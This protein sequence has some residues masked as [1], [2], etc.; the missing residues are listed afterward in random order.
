MGNGERGG[1]E[2]QMALEQESAQQERVPPAGGRRNFV[3]A[4]ADRRDGPHFAHGV[5]D[6]SALLDAG[7]SGDYNP[8]GEVLM[9]PASDFLD[10]HP[11]ARLVP[12]QPVHTG[13]FDL[14]DVVPTVLDSRDVPTGRLIQFGT[15]DDALAQLEDEFLRREQRIVEAN[16]G[17]LRAM[18]A[19]AEDERVANRA[20]RRRLLAALDELRRP[21]AAPPT[22]AE[23]AGGVPT[24][25]VVTSVEL[26]AAQKSLGLGDSKML[27]EE[28]EQLLGLAKTLSQTVPAKITE[29]TSLERL[30]EVVRQML[31]VC[32][33]APGG[34]IFTALV[35][36][37]TLHD[38]SM[39][40][41]VRNRNA[42]EA[43]VTSVLKEMSLSRADL[44]AL[45]ED[46]WQ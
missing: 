32:V 23:Q 42:L 4:A 46:S 14:R 11:S 22:A 45:E 40:K 28:K 35:T 6:A 16:R 17:T 19:A 7:S 2:E 39:M 26:T 8:L 33:T 21:A 43:G 30:Q 18:E 5:G 24:V 25:A 13:D 37:T 12:T 29:G 34:D 15:A 31:L 10:R 36:E 27:P 3:A 1:R 38:D 44:E 20:E 41:Q 9:S